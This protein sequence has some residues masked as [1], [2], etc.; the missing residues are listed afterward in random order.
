MMSHSFET[1][2]VDQFLKLPSGSILRYKFWSPAVN[3]KPIHVLMLQGRGTSIEKSEHFI[4]KLVDQGYTVWSFDWRGQG[5]STRSAG[6]RGYIDSYKT[7]LDDMG[8]FVE[9]LVLPDLGKNLLVLMGHSMGGHIG[10]RFLAENPG[11]FQAAL[12]AAPLMDLATGIYPK[13]VARML[14]NVMCKLGLDKAYIFGHG[15]YDPRTEPFEGNL[16]TRNSANFYEMRR[17]QQENP[18]LIVGGATFG[19]VGAT[20][21]STDVLMRPDYLGRVTVPIHLMTAGDEQIIDNQRVQLACGW[22]KRC[23]LEVIKGAKHQLF[24]ETDDVQAHILRVFNRLVEALVKE[25]EERQ[26]NIKLIKDPYLE[27]PAE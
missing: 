22:M 12:L 23:S 10:L 27:A 4:N 19:W 17:I 13:P 5:R 20:M 16:I 9:N 21:A 6:R 24:S 25:T 8:Y 3:P 14:T 2:A 18:D 1:K 26:K 15:Q 7:Y 11:I